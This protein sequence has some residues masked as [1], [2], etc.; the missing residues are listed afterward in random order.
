MGKA[1]ALR[2]LGAGRE[3]SWAQAT[4][5]GGRKGLAPTV[6]Q[7]CAGPWGTAQCKVNGLGLMGLTFRQE[8]NHKQNK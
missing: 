2:K 6:C 3:V 4:A 7:A 1:L 8:R 5:A